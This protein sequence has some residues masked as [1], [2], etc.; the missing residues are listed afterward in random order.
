[1]LESKLSRV[2]QVE[3]ALIFHEREC[4]GHSS[5]TPSLKHKCDI[6]LNQYRSYKLPYLCC[7]SGIHA[8]RHQRTIN[9]GFK[10]VFLEILNMQ[11]RSH[12][13]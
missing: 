1:M 4:K 7:E 10:V 11:I 6:A 12:I 3:C 2:T 9:S 13:A 5:G 8:V